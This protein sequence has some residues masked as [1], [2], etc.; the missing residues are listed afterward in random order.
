MADKTSTST[1]KIAIAVVS[2]IAIILLC[3]IGLVIIIASVIGGSAE[4]SSGGDASPVCT[5]GDGEDAEIEIPE[6]YQED[7][8]AAA[9]ESGFSAEVIGAQIQHESSW[10]PDAESPVGAQGIAQF[11]PETWESFGEGGDALNPEDSIA[12]QGRYMAYLREYMEDH[13]DDEEHLLELSLAGYNAGEGAVQNNDFD[14]DALYDSAPGYSNETQPYVDNIKTAAEGSYSSDCTQ[15][16]GGD[17]PSG[18]VTDAAMYLA[19]EDRVELS[20]SSAANHGR[21]ESKPE[22][23]EAADSINEDR[24]TAYYTDCGVYVATVMRTAGIDTSFPVRGTREQQPY[25][26]SSDDYEVFT[27]QSEGE[28]ESGDILI[29]TDHIYI[30]T[31]ERHS[32]DDG[33]ALGASLYTRPPSGHDFYLTDDVNGQY[34]AARFTGDSE[35]GSG[36]DNEDNDSL[37]QSDMAD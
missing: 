8:S 21:E 16:G 37:D 23:V 35:G 10:E 31:G 25:L 2:I 28:L 20:N 15:A 7:I 26:R 19:W 22:Y 9:E 1:T 13:A 11:M 4:D 3:M 32:G 29:A 24:H 36:D 5:P 17:V 30:Y 18:D 27:P 14:L 34:Y 6:E 12:A 33:R